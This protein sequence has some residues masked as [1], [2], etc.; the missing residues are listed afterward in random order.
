MHVLPSLRQR[1]QVVCPSSNVMSSAGRSFL[2]S[3]VLADGPLPLTL[4]RPFPFPLCFT[5]TFLPRP[6]G[7]SS[8]PSSD[9]SST[10]VR[11]PLS[12]PFLRI[13]L[14][15]SV[16]DSSSSY[17][18]L[19]FPFD[20]LLLAWTSSSSESA[21]FSPL[22]SDL[23]L[24]LDP[25]SASFASAASR[26]TIAASTWTHQLFGPGDD[27]GVSAF[28]NHSICIILSSCLEILL[29]RT[30]FCVVSACIAS[31]RALRMMRGTCTRFRCTMLAS[32]MIFLT[33]DCN[34]H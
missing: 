14:A 10:S 11:L 19:C 1:L 13:T 29:K 4:P 6:R 9:S 21:I 7:S 30:I 26:L 16:S 22:T 31:M 34:I 2:P 23:F 32:S 27:L 24:L 25:F 17:T 5:A 8:E 33:C 12:F 28:E 3:L 18:C 20:F 15:D